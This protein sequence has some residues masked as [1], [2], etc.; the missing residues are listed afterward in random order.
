MMDRL[1]F[2]RRCSHHSIFSIKPIKMH[3]CSIIIMI[4]TRALKAIICFSI[5]TSRIN[6]LCYFDFFKINRLLLSTPSDAH[7]SVAL[8]DPKCYNECTG[9]CW[10]KTNDK[11]DIK[12]MIEL[13]EPMQKRVKKYLDTDRND[14]KV[15]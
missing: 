13:T 2:S 6:S 3:A 1:L 4:P 15:S 7:E 5:H 12:F 10:C 8:V 14:S 11:K 9:F